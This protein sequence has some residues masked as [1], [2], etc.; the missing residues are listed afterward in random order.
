MCLTTMLLTFAHRR[1]HMIGIQYSILSIRD[2]L[3]VYIL[4]G[5]YNLNHPPYPEK[6]FW[7]PSITLKLLKR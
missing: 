7:L 3:N 5:Q 4:P 6:L 1:V 2:G